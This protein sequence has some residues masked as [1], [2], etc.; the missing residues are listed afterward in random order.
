MEGGMSPWAWESAGCDS[1]GDG[2]L[3]EG[4]ATGSS[5]FPVFG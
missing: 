5:V 3:M 1:G 4:A 2:C